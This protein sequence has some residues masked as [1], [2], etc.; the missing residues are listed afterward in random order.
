MSII[1]DNEYVKNICKPGTHQCCSY[2][3]VSGLGM[4]CFKESSLKKV[5]DERRAAGT[6]NAKEDNCKGYETELNNKN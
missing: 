3:G 4:E 5:I 6:M 2:L 1:K